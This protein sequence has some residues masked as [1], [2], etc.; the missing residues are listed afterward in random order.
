MN[1]RVFSLSSMDS[2]A[3]TNASSTFPIPEHYTNYVNVHLS[4]DKL[5]GK[6][7]DTWASDIRLWL[8]SQ[9]YVDHLTMFVD[10]VLEKEVSRWLKTDAQLCM[11]LK[12]T[13]H[14]SLKQIFLSY[15]TCSEIW[16]HVKLLYTN[17]TQRLY[18]VCQN[19]LHVVAS[20]RLNGPMSEYLGKIHALFHDFNELLPPTSTLSQEIEQ[21]S[22]FFMLLALYGLPDDYSPVRNQILGSPVVPTLT[23]TSS[24]LICVPDK[25][26]IDISTSGD[27]SSALVNVMIAPVLES[28]TKG[29][30]NVT[31]VA[32]L[33]TKLTGVMPYM[34][35]LL[36]LLQL[37]KQLLCHLL[38]WILLHLISQVH[39][40]FSMNFLNG[41]R[42]VRTLVPLH[43]L[44]IQVSLLLGSPTPILLVLG[45]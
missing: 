3:T 33:A 40:L 16:E 24:S 17:D 22:K 15:E 8:K 23:S 42:I 12:S 43:L 19:L 6:N 44:H 1:F 14:S 13:I 36:K 5:N 18:G 38:P 31:I 2:S 27:D 41:M 37:S 39:R 9:G 28:R 29:I 7:Y 45:F 35:V 26:H 34:A 10:N 21:Q 20:K 25:S 11:V 4:I 30:I 32:S